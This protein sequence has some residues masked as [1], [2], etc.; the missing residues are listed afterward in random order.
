MQSIRRAATILQ[1]LAAAGR[2]RMRLVDIVR[3]S[4]LK[5]SPVVRMLAALRAEGLVIFEPPTRSYRLGQRLGHLG[6]AA[7]IH[8]PLAEIARPFLEPLAASS[9]CD[10]CLIAREGLHSVLVMR[11]RGGEVER[12]IGQDVGMWRPLG[13]GPGGLALLA[14]FTEIEA[15]RMLVVLAREYARPPAL[16]I[17]VLRERLAETRRRGYALVRAHY[18]ANLGG[19][20]L[21]VPGLGPME[22]VAVSLITE[23]DQLDEKRAERLAKAAR[24]V[25]A[26]LADALE[27]YADRVRAQPDVDALHPPS[28]PPRDPSRRPPL[29]GGVRDADADQAS[30]RVRS[31]MGRNLRS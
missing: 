13:L 9:H 8:R 25:I 18:N 26:A 12:P 1:V 28:R 3:A 22:R 30:T 20:A 10:V 19:V 5:K 17:D 14:Q 2:R 6:G 21:S 23:L 7:V 4:G 31:A 16:S 24:P 29:A 11:C 27:E 15:E